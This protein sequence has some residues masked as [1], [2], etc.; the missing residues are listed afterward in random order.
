M[1]IG[2]NGGTLAMLTIAIKTLGIEPYMARQGVGL[3]LQSLLIVAA[4]F[5]MAGS[6]ISLMLSK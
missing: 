4:V 6:F 3:N 1:F 2:T 5:G